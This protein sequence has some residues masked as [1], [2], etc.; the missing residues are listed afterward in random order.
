MWLA[1]WGG[2]ISRYDGMQWKTFT[3]KDGL[4]DNMTRAL[5]VDS[6]GGLW[7]GTLTGINYFDGKNWITYTCKNT[8]SLA[9]DAVYTIYIRKK[10]DCLI[11]NEQRLSIFLRSGKRG[12]PAMATVM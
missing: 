4:V 12:R 7:I 10:W 1:T 3:V 5:A 6:Q 9:N 8:P 2:G 11:W